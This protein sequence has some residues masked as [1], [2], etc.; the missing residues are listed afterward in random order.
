M[1]KGKQAKAVVVPNTHQLALNDEEF[2]FLKA[3]A[4]EELEH[5]RSED[6]DCAAAKA[7][8]SLNSKILFE[9]QI[10]FG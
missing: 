9:S 3:M 1:E 4:E 10:D 5:L 7:C 6:P 2:E 8:K